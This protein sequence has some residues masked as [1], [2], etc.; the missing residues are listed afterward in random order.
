MVAGVCVCAF[1]MNTFSPPCSGG[2]RSVVTD[3]GTV[4]IPSRKLEGDGPGG[5]VTNGLG[6][7][8]K[9]ERERER[10]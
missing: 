7:K 9:K 3:G 10:E 6:G 2:N 4:Y 5:G 8:R 1:L